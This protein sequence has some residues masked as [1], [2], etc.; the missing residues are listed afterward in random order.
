MAEPDAL[1]RPMV[2]LVTGVAET[3][4]K[5]R[6]AKLWDLGRLVE[7]PGDRRTK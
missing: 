1:F 4:Q 5:R 6:P 3:Q 7:S 2:P